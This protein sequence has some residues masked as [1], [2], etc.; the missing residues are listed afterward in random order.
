MAVTKTVRNYIERRDHRLMR[1]LHRWRAPRFIQLLMLLSSRLGDGGLWYALGL[2]ILL[3]GGPLRFAADGAGL[4]SAL[5]AI[6]SFRRLKLMSRR[7]RPCDIEPHCWAM[8]TPPDQFSFPSGHSMTAFAIAVS[9]GSF[10]PQYQP[11]LLAVAV[12]IAASR[13]ILG[14]H[15]LTDVLAGAIAG[16]LLGFISFSFF[17]LLAAMP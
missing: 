10:Y 11:A 3:F 5:L 4:C 15:F 6:L 7:R 17:S 2:A 13:V 9:V 12:T 1:R 16:A 8:I 14:M